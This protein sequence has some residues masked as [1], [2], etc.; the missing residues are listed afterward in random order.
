[1]T[2]TTINFAHWGN[3][4]GR[5][6]MPKSVRAVDD[7]YSSPIGLISRAIERKNRGLAVANCRRDLQEVDRHGAVLSTHYELTIGK[8]VKTGGYNIVGSVWVAVKNAV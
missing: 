8:P 7:G 3:R 4:D 1:M 2:M 6:E 5:I